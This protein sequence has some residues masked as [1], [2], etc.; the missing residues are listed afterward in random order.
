MLVRKPHHLTWTGFGRF[1]KVCPNKTA[2][3]LN[4]AHTQRLHGKI[5]QPSCNYQRKRF[6]NVGS[7]CLKNSLDTRLREHLMMPEA[8][9]SQDDPEQCLLELLRL[10]S[11]SSVEFDAPPQALK[12]EAYEVARLALARARGELSLGTYLRMLRSEQR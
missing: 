6:E 8:N 9:Y 5:L 12:D 1:C 3:W 2:Y 11:S 7:G 10:G 4:D